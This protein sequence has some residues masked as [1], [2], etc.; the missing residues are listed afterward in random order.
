MDFKSFKKNSSKT[1]KDSLTKL[2]KTPANSYAD[3]RFWMLSKDSAGNG[4]A[5]LR[6][7]PQ[8]DPSESPVILTFRH[9]FQTGGMWF[10]EECPHT[11]GEKC[12]VCEYSSSIWNSNEDEARAHWR[13]KSYIAN[14]LVVEDKANPDN[15]GRVFLYK[16]GKT[17]YDKVMDRV[18]PDEEDGDEGVNVFDFDEGLDFRLKM[19]QKAGYNNY[20]K[21]AFVFKMSAIADGD[22]KVQET[23]YNAIYSLKE[24]TEPSKFKSYDELLKKLTGSRSASKVPDIQ[25]EFVKE[26]TKK[27]AYEEKVEEDK[28]FIPDADGGED[29]TEEDI[30][31]ESLLAD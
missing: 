12:P 2:A 24:F 8:K 30:D 5:V 28:P 16:F 27:P 13:K 14:V 7:L 4:A 9:A 20:D 15:E 29:A 11:I 21:S 31:F 6:F 25:S 10:I 18:A 17:I 23:T 22:L 1:L 19:G 3:D 26:T